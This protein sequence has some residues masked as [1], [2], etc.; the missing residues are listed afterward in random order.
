MKCLTLHSAKA[1]SLD[2]SLRFHQLINLKQSAYFLNYDHDMLQE[3]EKESLLSLTSWNTFPS[4]LGEWDTYLSFQRNLKLWL[5][6]GQ[7]CEYKL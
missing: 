7:V 5:R 4:K 1:K 6:D 2:K 3:H